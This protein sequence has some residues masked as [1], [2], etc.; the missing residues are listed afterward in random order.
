MTC[1]FAQWNAFDIY[2]TIWLTQV[3]ALTNLTSIPKIPPYQ[4]GEESVRDRGDKSST[5]G[6]V[7][8]FDRF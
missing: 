4:R 8:R 6:M 1:Y 7:E 2:V 3:R 5:F